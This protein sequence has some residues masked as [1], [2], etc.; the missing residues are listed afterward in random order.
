MCPSDCTIMATQLNMGTGHTVT[1]CEVCGD[2]PPTQKGYLLCVSIEQ[3]LSY[4][5]NRL[6]F[7]VINLNITELAR[8]DGVAFCRD[9]LRKRKTPTAP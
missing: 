3:N 9:I 4:A 1:H 8:Y 7:E 6:S 5:Q 2:T